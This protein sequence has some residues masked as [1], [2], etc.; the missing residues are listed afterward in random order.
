MHA[1]TNDHNVYKTNLRSHTRS[2]FHKN[3]HSKLLRG[4]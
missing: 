4:K 1:H 3:S 2:K